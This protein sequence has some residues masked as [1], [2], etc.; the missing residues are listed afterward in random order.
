[1]PTIEEL[2]SFMDSV[3]MPAGEFQRYLRRLECVRMTPGTKVKIEDT[4]HKGSVAIVEGLYDDVAQVRITS[5]NEVVR[6][7]VD[8]LRRHFQS[9]DT[10][11]IIAGE[12]QGITGWITKV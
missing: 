8:S 10:V 7:H 9:G 6:F 4:E 11:K 3:S 5:T 12:H 2:H 1:L